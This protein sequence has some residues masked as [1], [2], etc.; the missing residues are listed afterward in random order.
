MI[1]EDL[2]AERIAIDSYRDFIA[3]L[4]DRT[5][6]ATRL[7]ERKDVDKTAK[8]AASS[9]PAAEKSAAAPAAPK[10]KQAKKK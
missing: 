9:K 2:V 6:K 3:Y 8:A 5:G 4:S 1:K 7:T 10:P